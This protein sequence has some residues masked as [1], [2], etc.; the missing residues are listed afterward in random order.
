VAKRRRP[1]GGN[2]TTYSCSMP[3]RYKWIAHCLASLVSFF[4]GLGLGG[5][6]PVLKLQVSLVGGVAP[7]MKWINRTKG[8][9]IC[10]P[11]LLYGKCG[12]IV[13]MVS[14]VLPL[15]MWTR[16]CGMSRNKA[17]YGVPP[18]PGSSRVCSWE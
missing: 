13:M 10:R 17:P 2:H 11:S 9:L 6:C 5:F 15:Q 16:L 14:L 4:S 7:S 8:A 1:S 3:L 18:E 12:N